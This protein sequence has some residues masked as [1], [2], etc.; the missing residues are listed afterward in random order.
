GDLLRLAVVRGGLMQSQPGRGAMAVV[1]ADV[2]VVLGVVPRFAG[3][4]VAAFNA[5]RSVTVSGPAQAV[6][7]FVAGSGLRARP[8][9]VSHAFH[10][11]LMEGAVQPFAEAVAGAVLSAPRVA[12]ASSVT[13]GW[14][15]AQSAVD[16]GHWGRGVREPVRFGDAVGL[17]GGVGA[18]VVWEIGAQPQLTSSARASWRGEQQP[19]WL[20]TLRRERVDQREMHQALAAYADVVPGAIDWAGVHAGKGHRTMTLPTYPFNRKRYWV[21]PPPHTPGSAVPNH[22]QDLQDGQHP[23]HPNERHQ[24]HG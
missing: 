6:E 13:G 11:A 23:H 4:E 21:S 12:F 1:H 10:S 5:P 18:G 19:L 3:V 20:T 16:P 7:R 9:V 15:T 8:L 22:R 14:H 24:H 17:L 2:D